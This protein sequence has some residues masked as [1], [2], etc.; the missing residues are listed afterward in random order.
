MIRKLVQL[1][2]FLLI[3]NAVY[4]IAPV[5]YHFYEFKDALQELALF[6]QKST[7]AEL[8]DRVMALADEHSIPLDRDDVRI[9][10]LNGELIIDASYVESMKVLPGYTYDRQFDIEA[11]AF[12]PMR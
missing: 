12:D 7:D 4:R 8:T 5:S 11:K 1:A 6:S 9:R 3:A 10:R 2:I